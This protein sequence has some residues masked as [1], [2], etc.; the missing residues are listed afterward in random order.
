MNYIVRSTAQGAA[1]TGEEPSSPGP[2]IVLERRSCDVAVPSVEVHRQSL[3]PTIDRIVTPGSKKPEHT[4]IEV[5]VKRE[6]VTE[7]DSSTPSPRNIYFFK[8]MVDGRPHFDALQEIDSG[9]TQ[10]SDEQANTEY[11]LWET[12]QGDFIYKQ[13]G[14]D[15]RVLKCIGNA[16]YRGE[17]GDAQV[18]HKFATKT[19]GFIAIRGPDSSLDVLKLA[20]SGTSFIPL[21]ESKDN[22]LYHARWHRRVKRIARHLGLNLRTFYDGAGKPMTADNC[23][24]WRAGHIEKKLA[25]YMVYA[26]V[27]AHDIK[28]ADSHDI[29]LKDLN[30]LRKR[31][32]YQGLAPHYE[33]HISRAPCGTPQRPGQCI[34]FENNL[35]LDGSVPHRPRTRPVNKEL[36]ALHSQEYLAVSSLSS[37]YDSEEEDLL[38]HLAEAE[39]RK[40]DIVY[41]GF[42]IAEDEPRNYD[43]CAADDDE[44]ETT[45]TDSSPLPQQHIP[46]EVATKF[47]ENLRAKFTR[48]EKHTTGS[49]PE[50]TE[51]TESVEEIER[52][53]SYVD[54][55][56]PPSQ[57]QYWEA[58]ATASTDVAR[59]SRRGASKADSK[60]RRSLKVKKRRAKALGKKHSGNTQTQ[61]AVLLGCWLT[62][63][64]TRGLCFCGSPGGDT[65]LKSADWLMQLAD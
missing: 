35:I 63:C 24:N 9:R 42:E 36:S 61:N 56:R 26:M 45:D 53:L 12:E 29:S 47:G 51:S 7:G 27:F 11:A 50:T 18:K 10:L 6:P 54:L 38:V 16:E 46:P 15:F 33:I 17:E 32:R 52:E 43:A 31:L 41:D 62:A 1:S 58:P 57:S 59:P 22:F 49:T 5:A 19:L 39:G 60:M 21:R 37:D 44:A 55:D 8:R 20:V 30:R 4:D 2:V 34:P 3:P 40:D 14:T 65:R 64:W 25:T 48:K 23:G 13:S 28:P